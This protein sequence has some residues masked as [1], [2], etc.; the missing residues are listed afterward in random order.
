MA[1]EDDVNVFRET[2]DDL[3]GLGQRR[4]S[5]EERSRQRRT[6]EDSL[7]RPA[8]PKILF[9][10]CGRTQPRAGGHLA[11]DGSTLRSRKLSESIHLRTRLM[12]SRDSV[13]CRSH[14]LW[15][16]MRKLLQSCLC[17]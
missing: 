5:F 8:D 9:N 2:V 17:I 7:K 12:L 3:V 14:P 15:R 13:Y 1:V 11:K 16:M 4:S 6:R 10:D